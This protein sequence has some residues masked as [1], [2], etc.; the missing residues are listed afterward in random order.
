MFGRLT[1][2]LILHLLIPV[3][4]V[5][6]TFAAAAGSASNSPSRI[7]SLNLCTDQLLMLLAER[8]TIASVTYLAAN[9]ETSI[10]AKQVGDIYLNHGQAEEIIGLSPDLVLAGQ[11]GA[12]AGVNILQKLGYRVEKFDSA[13]N[14][15]GIRLNLRRLGSLI[16]RSQKAES[17]I[18]A[19]DRILH[20]EVITSLESKRETFTTYD[21]NGY[22]A[23]KD[24]LLAAVAD[25][26]GY[27]TLGDRLGFSGYRQLPLEELLLIKPDLI[28]L[29][30]EWSQPPSLA[31]E[32][33]RH[34]ALKVLLD[35][36]EQMDL[37]GATWTC[38]LPVLAEVVVKLRQKRLEPGKSKSKSI[39]KRLS[40]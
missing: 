40:L 32:S 28:D 25:A 4:A 11:Y 12:R 39:N 37:P 34:P 23:G 21:V 22:V 30:N 18:A 19:M 15:D 16:H 29:G 35:Q 36:T 20:A 6:F 27:Q 26:A 2:I 9:A 31:S 14:F 7:V 1:P 13:H 24:T 33:M 5:I 17:L 3:V 38:G 8:Q 10:M